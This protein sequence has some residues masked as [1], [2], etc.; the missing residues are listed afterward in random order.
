[1][2]RV[3]AATAD[4]FVD[5]LR[6][7]GRGTVRAVTRVQRIGRT[8]ASVATEIRDVDDRVAAAGRGGYVMAP[9]EPA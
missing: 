6:P 1:M 4:L 8:R 5:Y 3:A 2:N 9:R 7:P